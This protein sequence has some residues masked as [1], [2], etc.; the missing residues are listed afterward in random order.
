SERSAEFRAQSQPVTVAAIQ[1]A[2]PDNAALIEFATYRP[3]DPKAVN[4]DEA[5][6]KPHYVAYVVRREAAPH[7][8]DLGEAKAINDAID[9]WRRALRD[10]QRS[11]TRELARVVDEKVMRPIRELLGDAK[12]LL[13]SPDGELNLIPF[14]ALVDEQNHYLIER[15]SFTYLTSGRDLLRL[16]VRRES[17]GPPVVVADPAF[18]G[19]ALVASSGRAGADNSGVSARPRI[20]YAQVFFGT[21]PGAA[22]EV[23][24]LRGLLPQASFLTREQAT[25]AALKKL[26]GPSIL[27]VATHGFFLQDEQ[28]AAAENRA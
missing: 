7:G 1:A 27:H 24:A 23:R 12:Q 3:F 21:L 6:G 9:A 14:A 15:Y 18:G 11:D 19:P 8:N 10:P 2:I 17:K 28:Q 22:E 13:V 26:S 16:Q 4:S 20:D 25:K 5:F